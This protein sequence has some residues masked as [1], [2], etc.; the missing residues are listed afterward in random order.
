MAIKYDKI[1]RC[2]SCMKEN[3][4]VFVTMSPTLIQGQVC[5]K[6]LDKFKI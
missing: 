1:G 2:D 5:K 6:C 4:R 3:Q